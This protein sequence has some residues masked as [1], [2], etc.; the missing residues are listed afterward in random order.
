MALSA[1]RCHVHTFEP[2]L[3][4]KPS[5]TRREE[6]IKALE[7]WYHEGAFALGVK[8]V[9]SSGSGTKGGPRFPAQE[10]RFLNEGYRLFGDPGKSRPGRPRAGVEG[11]S[12]CIR[13]AM[14]RFAFHP[15]RTESSLKQK[16]SS[17]KK[18]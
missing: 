2:L 9:G 12:S 11:A 17:M 18:Q 16:W 8:S 4:R 14:D 13:R 5:S 3:E 7:C 6:L 1:L 15:S 10:V